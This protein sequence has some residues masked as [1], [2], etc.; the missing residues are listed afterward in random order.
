MYGRF[1]LPLGD[2]RVKLQF[3]APRAAHDTSAHVECFVG[4]AAL[5]GADHGHLAGH[6]SVP[7]S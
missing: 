3:A 5:I 7:A 1:V 4:G 6:T 2:G